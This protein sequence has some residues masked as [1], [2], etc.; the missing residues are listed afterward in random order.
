MGILLPPPPPM[1]E[2]LVV[3]SLVHFGAVCKDHCRLV[4]KEVELRKKC[5]AG[6]EGEVTKLMK[7]I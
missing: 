7:N 5:I 1:M 6:I 2:Y 4:P 3:C